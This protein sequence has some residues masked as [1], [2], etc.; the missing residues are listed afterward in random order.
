[1]IAELLIGMFIPFAYGGYRALTSDGWDDSNI[2]NWFRLIWHVFTHPEDF[3]RMFYLSDFQEDI[4]IHEGQNPKKP[5]S[6][7]SGDELSDNFPDARP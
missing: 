2:F 7:I 6:Y 4:L 5:F 3:G 1:M